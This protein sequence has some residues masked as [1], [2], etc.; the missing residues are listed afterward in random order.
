VTLVIIEVGALR[1]DLTLNRATTS[2]SSDHLTVLTLAV[3]P[4]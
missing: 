4:C 3:Q 1:P 2:L